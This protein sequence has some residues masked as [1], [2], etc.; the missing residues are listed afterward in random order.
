MGSIYFKWTW[1]WYLSSSLKKNG[2]KL[3]HKLT[4][5]QGQILSTKTTQTDSLYKPKR[6]LVLASLQN[7]LMTYEPNGLSPAAYPGF[8]SMKQLWTFLLPPGWDAI[9]SQGYPEH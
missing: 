1:N 9:P 8:C 3:S 2:R 5:C 7:A 6:S 4:L